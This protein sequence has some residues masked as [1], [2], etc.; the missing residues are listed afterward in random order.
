MKIAVNTRLLLKN[1]MEGIGVHAYNVLKRITVNHPEHQFLFLFDR[2]YDE[3]FVFSSNVTPVVLYPQARH[4]LLYYWWFEY[5]VAR[6][7]N[8]VKPDIFYSPDGFLSLNTEVRSVPV[9]HD[10]N[11]EHYPQDLPKWASW[12]YRHFFPKFAAKARRIITVS[13]F[14]KQDIVQNYNIH[15]DKIDVVYNA[16]HRNYR[17]MAENEKSEMRNKYSGGTDYFLYVSALHPRKNVKRL[18]EAF[19][20]VKESSGSPIKLV[21]VGP[22]YFKNSEMEKTYQKMKFKNDVVFTGRLNVEELSKVMGAAF[23]LVYV[24]YFEGFGI[25][26]VEAMQ[27]DVPIVASDIT[28]IPEVT[29]DAARMVDPFSIDSIADGMLEILKNQTLRTELIEKGRER[30]TAFSWKNTA[31]LTWKSLEKAAR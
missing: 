21:L 23:A 10:L 22:H 14:S 13:E 25:P 9:I 6:T 12:H 27:C 4:P 16:A 8:R 28:S 19:D 3:K 15:A 26:L 18:L 5:S 2:K 30:C 17:V 11:Y 7:L 31:E 24:S 20:K 29:R 1:K